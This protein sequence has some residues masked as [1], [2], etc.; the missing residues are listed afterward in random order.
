MNRITDINL[1]LSS[2][3]LNQSNVEALIQSRHSFLVTWLP[4]SSL[5]QSQLDDMESDGGTDVYNP[6]DDS[7]EMT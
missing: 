6:E 4:L 3:M 7:T 1:P 2:V 5:S